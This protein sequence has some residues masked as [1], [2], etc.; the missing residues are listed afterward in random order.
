[1][2]PTLVVILV[3]STSPYSPPDFS[4]HAAHIPRNVGIRPTGA[5]SD[6]QYDST[7]D[8]PGAGVAS[9]VDT[10]RSKRFCSHGNVD[11]SG[12]HHTAMSESNLSTTAHIEDVSNSPSAARM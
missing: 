5:S 2:Y 11:T 8:V 1:M 10:D 3:S 12:E 7:S 6:T 4:Y 9:E